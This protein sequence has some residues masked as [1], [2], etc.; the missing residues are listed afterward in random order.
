MFHE[1][2]MQH[3]TLGISGHAAKATGSSLLDKSELASEVDQ[4]NRRPAISS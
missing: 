3:K 4:E 1:K 2:Y